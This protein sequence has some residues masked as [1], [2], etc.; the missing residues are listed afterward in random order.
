MIELSR[1]KIKL[2]EG[3]LEGRLGCSEK[4][5]R[6]IEQ[7]PSFV[8]EELQ[9][10]CMNYLV[11]KAH[12]SKSGCQFTQND[13]P[14]ARILSTTLKEKLPENVRT[15]MDKMFIDHSEIHENAK[16]VYTSLDI[17]NMLI[18]TSIFSNPSPK[19]DVSK[20][21]ASIKI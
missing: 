8:T 20:E 21:L 6:F 7:N 15:W 10:M 3:R 19:E 1:E 12:H 5:Q 14:I 13:L 17:R 18:Y 9:N 11:L 4:L 2:R 16:T